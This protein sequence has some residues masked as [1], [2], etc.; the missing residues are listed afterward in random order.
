M[1]RHAKKKL[2]LKNKQPI[3][4]TAV[5]A[6]YKMLELE[7]PLETVE[8]RSLISHGMKLKYK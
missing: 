3:T 7:E 6:N 2:K 1:D 8:S 5:T 4:S